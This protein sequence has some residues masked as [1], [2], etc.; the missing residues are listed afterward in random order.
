VQTIPYLQATVETRHGG[1]LVILRRC[2][3]QFVR[4]CTRSTHLES[5]DHIT[6]HIFSIWVFQVLLYTTKQ[7]DRSVTLPHMRAATLTGYVWGYLN[8][9]KNYMANTTAWATT[10]RCTTLLCRFL[11]S[12]IKYYCYKPDL[13]IGTNFTRLYTIPL[14]TQLLTF[15]YK[16]RGKKIR[17]HSAVFPAPDYAESCTLL[18]KSAP[19]QTTCLTRMGKHR[20]WKRF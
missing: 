14:Q 15:P 3:K 11:W 1:R 2:V 7:T 19:N 9:R 6:K 17:I 12:N 4:K 13:L 8:I 5:C 16:K 10:N 20:E 18:N